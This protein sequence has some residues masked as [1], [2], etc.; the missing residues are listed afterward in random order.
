MTQSHDQESAARVADAGP[1]AY[2]LSVHVVDDARAPSP[3]AIAQAD[4]DVDALN[5]ELMRAGAWVFAGGL[6]RPDTASVVRASADDVT[7]SD[8]PYVEGKEHIGGF[9]IISVADLDEALEWA[10]RATVACGQPVEVRPFVH[11]DA[12]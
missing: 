4:A 12:A 10:A 5:D 8:G 6:Q 11:G 2:L 1:T 3:D 9:W 7:T